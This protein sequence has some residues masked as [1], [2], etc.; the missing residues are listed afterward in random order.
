MLHLLYIISILK[1]RGALWGGGGGPLCRE[2]KSPVDAIDLLLK[3][4]SVQNQSEKGN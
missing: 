3:F 1:N 4:R 2:T